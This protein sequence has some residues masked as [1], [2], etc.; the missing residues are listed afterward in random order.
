MNQKKDV[1]ENMPVPKAVATLALP[2]ILSM[3]VTVIYNL[4][5]TY[6]VGQTGDPN[7]VAAV[8][9]VTPIFLVMLAFGNMFGIGGSSLISRMLGESKLEKVKQISS[10]ALYGTLSMGVLVAVAFS[11]NMPMLLS[12]IGT[13]EN[14][15]AFSRGYLE[16]I[17]MGAPFIIASVAFSNIVRGEG[18]AKAAMFGMMA[19]TITNIILDPVMIL[20]M[21]LG[22]EG[23]AIATVIGN[24][25]SLGIFLWYIIN[26]S[27]VLSVHPKHFKISD[28][29][30][31]GVF[32]I[33]LPASINNLLMSASNVLMN[34]FLVSYGD[35]PV[36]AMGVA[37]KANMLV[38]MLQIGLSMGIQPLVGYSF[39]ARNFVR[40][41]EVMR[42]TMICIVIMGTVLTSIY[43]LTADQIIALFIDDVSVIAYGVD[44]LRALMIAGPV[45]GIMFVF[46]SSFQAMGKAIPALILSV[47]RQGLVFLPAV[48]I[49]NYVAGLS[50]IVYAQPI[51]DI[52][53]IFMSFGMFI[54][55]SKRMHLNDSSRVGQNEQ[56]SESI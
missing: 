18:A 24:M 52:V 54:F 6:F 48:I 16:W 12:I 19:G 32:A 30:L 38:I 2:T 56:L 44:M 10:F 13:S 29:I 17:A 45:V 40:M 5:D 46:M 36:A 35:I 27:T 8:S 41:K 31:T 21:G 14:T 39:G 22:V 15:I 28:G 49:G 4:V 33:G 53:S 42:F 1:F 20:W 11:A 34:N 37:M 7:Q 50:G 23:A 55:I 47:S 3:L 9:I 51:A 26:R 43:V 25:V